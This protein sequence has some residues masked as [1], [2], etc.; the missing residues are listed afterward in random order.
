M[1]WTGQ[2]FFNASQIAE[3]QL[4]LHADTSEID[5][6]YG[7]NQT[8][9]GSSATIG[10]GSLDKGDGVMFGFNQSVVGPATSLHWTPN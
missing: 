7:P 10:L 3:L 5:F 1:Q 8:L 2:S 4:I 9:T 6:V